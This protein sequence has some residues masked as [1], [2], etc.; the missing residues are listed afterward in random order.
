MNPHTIRPLTVLEGVEF[1]KSF[2]TYLTNIGEKALLEGY[3]W[4]IQGPKENIIVDTGVKPESFTLLRA[5][6]KD[7]G[8]HQPRFYTPEEA[9]GR[10]G[11][12][13]QDID[14]V[15][16]THLHF[17]HIEQGEKYSRAKFIIQRDELDYALNPHPSQALFLQKATFEHLNFEVIEG[18]CEIVPGVKVLLTPGHTHGGQ[19]V[20]VKTDKGTTVIAGLCTI[21]E[22]FYPP[23][24]LKDIMPVI[25][26]AIHKD[27]CQA[28]DSL[29]RIKEI[30]DTIYPLQQS[31]LS[32]L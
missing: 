29:L 3:I 8:A 14:L 23:D 20:A 13:P 9:L 1:E 11:L 5:L 16:V 21:N 15:I 4:Y 30:A 17:D 26:P 25:T 12:S 28:Y 18:D 2:M 31:G 7:S 10:I 22:N 32:R 27:P 19:S 6:F 24:H